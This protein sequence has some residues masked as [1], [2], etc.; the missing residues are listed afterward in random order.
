MGESLRTIFACSAAIA[1][2]GCGDPSRTDDGFWAILGEKT[3]VFESMSSVVSCSL[4]S[5][6]AFGDVGPHVAFDLSFET[7]PE[8]GFL[9]FQLAPLPDPLR[10]Q[11]SLSVGVLGFFSHVRDDASG[12]GF[13]RDIVGRAEASL[14][15]DIA[16]AGGDMP[17]REVFLHHLVLPEQ[18]LGTPDGRTFTLA[19]R[20]SD[21]RLYCED[22]R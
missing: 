14:G 4:R 21:V 13:Y 22:F 15:K 5:S 18:P 6:T 3:G 17:L 16:R 19:G 10:G 11:R 2:L 20:L 7:H 1:L 9:F 12:E 8:V